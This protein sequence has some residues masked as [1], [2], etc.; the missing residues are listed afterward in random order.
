MSS[1]IFLFDDRNYFVFGEVCSQ[2]DTMAATYMGVV[3]RSQQDRKR[4]KLAFRNFSAAIAGTLLS[5]TV[6]LSST[7]P[8]KFPSSLMLGK[9]RTTYEAEN[10]PIDKK[11]AS[12]FVRAKDFLG[13]KQSEA[14]QLTGIGKSTIE[15]IDQGV[16]PALG[17][18]VA[19]RMLPLIELC[20]ILKEHFGERKF[21]A[22]A[23]LRTPDSLLGDVSPLEYALENGPEGLKEIISLERKS[24]G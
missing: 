22:R 18:Q 23:R 17:N 9:Q 7:T 10:I 2:S 15:K 13:I 11:I 21:I 12:S 14:A 6:L 4:P 1:S 3:E 8:M 16:Y 20:S 19:I 24:L 5:A